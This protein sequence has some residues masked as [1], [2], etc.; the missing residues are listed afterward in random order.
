MDKRAGFDPFND[1]DAYSKTFEKKKRDSA[2]A[3]WEGI[4]TTI[5]SEGAMAIARPQATESTMEDCMPAHPHT[6]QCIMLSSRLPAQPQK[7][8]PDSEIVSH[9]AGNVLTCS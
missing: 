1:Q 3:G 7:V 9:I 4:C 5:L 6:Q 2:R 8:C